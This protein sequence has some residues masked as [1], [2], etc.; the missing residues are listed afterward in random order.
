MEHWRVFCWLIE[1][2]R[3]KRIRVLVWEPPCTS[4]SLAR[5]PKLRRTWCAEGLDTVDLNTARGNLHAYQSFVLARIQQRAGHAH[6]GEPPYGGHMK[7][8]AGWK[9]LQSEGSS[10]TAFDWCR[11][12]RTW[13]K[14]TALC[15]YPKLF[16]ALSLRCNCPKGFKHIQREGSLTTAAASYSASFGKAVAKLAHVCPEPHATACLRAQSYS[17]LTSC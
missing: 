16:S 10:L 4:F 6:I 5:T 3:A 13:K 1:L 15:H 2:T 12:G 7:H 17:Q 11:F 8:T 9:L 14:T